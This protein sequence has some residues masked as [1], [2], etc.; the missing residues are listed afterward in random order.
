MKRWV[1]IVFALIFATVLT[2]CGNAENETDTGNENGAPI[3]DDTTNEEGVE[4]PNAT[5][6]EE[7]LVSLQNPEGEVVGTATLTPADSGVDIKLEGENLPPGTK[8]F[9]IHEV[10]QCDPPD[11]ESAGSH[12]NPTNDEHGFDHSDGPHAG[13]LENIEVAEDGTVTA[14]VTA[15]MLTLDK[16]GENTLYTDEGTALVIHSEAD[17][18]TSQPAGDAGDR[19]ACGVIGE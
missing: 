6:E 16:D 14:E 3:E 1:M 9:H 12:Y 5:A 11:F 17:D 15:D 2:A 8:G 19:I 4:D 18:Y 10:G 13:D 7:V